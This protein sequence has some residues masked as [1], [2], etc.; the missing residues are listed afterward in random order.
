MGGL[1]KFWEHLDTVESKKGLQVDLL[2]DVCEEQAN[3]S[4]WEQSQETVRLL[5]LGTSQN[6]STESS[7]SPQDD[8]NNNSDLSEDEIANQRYG[9]LYQEI[10][11]DKEEVLT[12]YVV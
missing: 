8:G 9:L 7:T 5:F 11:A 12:Q 2:A 1:D 3:D 6:V 4:C 10:G